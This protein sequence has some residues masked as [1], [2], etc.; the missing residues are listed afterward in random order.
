MMPGFARKNITMI[1]EAAK[2]KRVAMGPDASKN[3][4]HEDV[5]W[6]V[7][8][9]F[10]KEEHIR[11]RKAYQ[12]AVRASHTSCIFKEFKDCM[13]DTCR[14]ACQRKFQVD[15]VNW[16]TLDDSKLQRWL[17]ICFGPKSKEEAISRL[18]AV[19]FPSH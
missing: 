12:M 13:T 9:A 5:K 2:A 14:S 10:T 19:K 4:F 18:T 11:V 7:M 3:S 15:D 8:M 1:I 6:P 16:I 17:A